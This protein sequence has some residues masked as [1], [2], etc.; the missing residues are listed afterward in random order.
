LNGRADQR[1]DVRVHVLV[2]RHDG[3]DDLDFVLEPFRE[4]RTNRAIDQ[5]T[6]QRFF[7]GRTAFTTEET[8]R[9]LARRVGFFLVIHRQRKEVDAGTSSFQ[10]DHGAQHDGFAHRDEHGAGSLTG[11]TPRLQDHAVIAVL[12][13][14]CYTTQIYI[15]LFTPGY[16]LRPSRSIRVA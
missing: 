8:A 6:R 14:L 15:L 9:D 3:A 7:L 16:R 12:E 10:S 13:F 11:K 2:G 4:Q 5:T 1:R